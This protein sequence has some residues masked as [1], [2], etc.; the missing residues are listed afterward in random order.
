MRRTLAIALA[1]TLFCGILSA[2]TPRFFPDTI[3]LERFV[4]DPAQDMLPYPSGFD[5]S[6]VNYDMDGQPTFEGTPGNWFWDSEINRDSGATDNYGMM[7]VSWLLNPAAHNYNW[8][9]LPLLDIP[10]SAYM[11][12][13]RSA[14]FQ[15]PAYMDGYKVLVSEEGNIPES[16]DFANILFEAASTLS[17]NYACANL[18]PLNLDCY[19]FTDGYVHADGFTKTEYFETRFNADI[20]VYLHYG[21]L[22]PHAV[23]LA[24]FA[25][26]LIYVAFLHDAFDCNI[27]QIDD[28][29]VARKVGIATG[30]PKSGIAGFSVAPTVAEESA[31]LEWALRNREEVRLQVSDLQ[32][33]I[34][35]ERRYS[36]E[37][38]GLLHLS[39]SDFSPG[40]YLVSLQTGSGLATCKL[41][42]R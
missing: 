34:V 21:F 4:F 8:L 12:Y 15:G 14:P 10:D 22:E 33:R 6:W 5:V 40:V 37:T 1:C 39:L 24:A 26:K 27:L 28:I 16:G 30:D 32:G 38:S 31:Y 18:D 3:I 7:S 36:G 29:V 42:K 35:T 13:W 19:T 9:I 17:T 25:N 20:G 2:Q 41:I 11:L 23:S